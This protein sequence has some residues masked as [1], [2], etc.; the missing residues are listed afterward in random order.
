MVLLLAVSLFL[1]YPPGEKTKLG[2]DL[3]G[4]L[5]VILEAQGDV[6][7]DKMDQA[8]LVVRKRVDKLGVSEPA[9]NRQGNNQIS[10]GLAG[11]KNVEDAMALIGKTALLEFKKVDSD[12]TQPVTLD[13]LTPATLPAS[14]HTFS[15][16]QPDDTLEL[17]RVPDAP[18]VHGHGRPGALPRR[19]CVAL[20]GEGEECVDPDPDDDCASQRGGA[21]DRCGQP[22]QP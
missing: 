5:E 3:Q 11:V 17:P 19:L 15:H 13:T 14:I 7:S 18:P 2:L 21:T 6:T 8:E 1:I 4:G 9:I 10:V 22:G 20:L 12:T 16:T